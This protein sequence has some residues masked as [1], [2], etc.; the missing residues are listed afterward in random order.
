MNCSIS[1]G[2]K[3]SK[4]GPIYGAMA[5]QLP[6]LEPDKKESEKLTNESNGSEGVTGS[7]EVTT[8]TPSEVIS[9][10][11]FGR[12][13]FG[14]QAVFASAYFSQFMLVNMMAYLSTR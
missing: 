5:E 13:Q 10:L 7:R 6:G 9:S 11:G 1:T 12:A 3:Q 2:L 14:I 4:T 8:L